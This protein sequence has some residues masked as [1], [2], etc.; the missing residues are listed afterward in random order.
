MKATTQEER[1]QIAQMIEQGMTSKEIGTRLGFSKKTIDKWRSRIRTSSVESKMGRPRLGPMGGS[2]AS[3]R[4]KVKALRSEHPSWGGKMIGCELAELGHQPPSSTTIYRYIK[5]Q[6]LIKGNE[7]HQTQAFFPKI[8]ANAPH[9]VWQ[10]D[11]QGNE[12]VNSLGAYS[13]LNAKDVFSGVHVGVHPV[14]MKSE[15]GHPTTR[16]YQAVFRH[17][18]MTY[19]LPR[20]V[21][22]DHASIFYDNHSKSPFPTSFFLWLV[23]MDVEPVFSRIHQPQDQ[24]KVER[25]H[26]TMWA[27]IERSTPYK[28]H[29]QFFDYCQ[30]RRAW[31]NEKFPSSPCGNQPPLTAY[32]N[33]IH[34]GQHYHPS[35]EH[36]KCSIDRVYDYLQKG[37]WWRKVS[38]DS[39]IS[40]GGQVYY[41]KNAKPNAQASIQFRKSDASLLITI[42]NELCFKCKIKGLEI[43]DLIGQC[44]FPFPGVQLKLPLFES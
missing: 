12:Q 34:S 13:I 6:G 27:Q 26:Q 15:R 24:G 16:D 23:A 21:Q 33:A 41:L 11:G 19:G 43:D 14:Y 37:L 35:L 31:L 8:Q 4:V 38:K 30:K 9:D 3:L 29:D 25:S 42:V 7:K 18:A 32:P 22:T 17:A 10:I 2:T 40:I 28:T 39:T 36:Q 1:H 5:Q 44:D 20:Q